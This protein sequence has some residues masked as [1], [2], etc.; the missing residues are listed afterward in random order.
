MSLSV[1]PPEEMSLELCAAQLFPSEDVSVARHHGLW[2]PRQQL[3]H[4]LFEPL[5]PCR[6]RRRGRGGG[7]G[8]SC[9]E[10]TAH[11]E[12]FVERKVDPS[13]KKKNSDARETMSSNGDDC[14]EH[15]KYGILLD[16]IAHQTETR[17]NYNPL[18]KRTQ[19]LTTPP[20]CTHSCFK[21]TNLSIPNF[22]SFVPIGTGTA[23]NILA[24]MGTLK[25]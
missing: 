12:P 25:H 16:H 8:G 9:R 13:K 6:G 21:S 24:V 2:L 11:H 19:F 15:M 7:R 3:R 23:G 4:A 18:R 14:D 17:P 10:R 20:P 5:A 22:Q 1:L